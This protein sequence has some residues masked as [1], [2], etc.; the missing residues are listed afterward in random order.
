MKIIKDFKKFIK[1]KTFHNK[2][3]TLMMGIQNQLKF[4]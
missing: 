3:K 2:S 4:N 1:N